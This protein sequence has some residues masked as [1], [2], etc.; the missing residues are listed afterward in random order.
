MNKSKYKAHTHTHTH[1]Y[2]FSNRKVMN[3]ERG[4]ERERM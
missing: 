1:A 2:R 4:R 3:G